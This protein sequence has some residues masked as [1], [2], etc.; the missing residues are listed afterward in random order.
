M[1]KRDKA[2]KFGPVE[3]VIL[4]L[5][6]LFVLVLIIPSTR[7]FRFYT[8]RSKCGSNLSQIGKAML[9][10]AADYDG[11][12]PRS[13]YGS[14]SS[15]FYL[16][17]KHSEV[18]PKIFVCPADVGTIEFNPANVV[19]D[20]KKLTD[21]WD[22]G[23]EPYKHCSY[24]YHMPFGLYYLRTSDEPGKP[25]AADRNP[26]ID[27]PAAEAK[28][29]FFMFNPDGGRESVKVANAVTHNE[30]GQNVVFLDG[31]VSFEENPSC[32]IG[33]DNI[34]TFWDG[35]DIRSGSRPK[36]GSEPIGKTDSLLVHDSRLYSVTGRIT[37]AKQS[38]SADSKD[39]KQTTVVATIDCPMPEHKNVIWC[40][41]FQIAWDRF[42]NDIIEEPI[43]LIGVQGLNDRLNSNEFSPENL[44]AESFYA[45][46][47]FFKDG[48]IEQIKKDMANRFPSEPVPVFDRKYETLPDV[49][50]AYAFL[51]V[52]AGFKYPFYTRNRKF[53]FQDSK[54][55]RTDVTSF[56][57][58]AE[59]RDS[60]YEKIREQVEVLYY[61]YGQ[62]GSVV[63][64]AI[65]LCT[66]TDPYQVI[67]ARVPRRQTLSETLSEVQKK[68]SEF[69]RDPDYDVLRKL[70]PIDSL[71]VPDILYKLTHR[72]PG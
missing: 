38:K 60:N 44:E 25:V 10:Y 35:G 9:A 28:E 4:I 5:V 40:G 8:Y 26:W 24:S 67:L 64:F 16:L 68:I 63:E 69:K 52:D 20:D 65:D 43:K 19:S 66:H 46:A 53:T 34:Y 51:S 56:S 62:E 7:M 37:T 32:G 54:G 12:L 72:A 30:Q 39:L 42:K 15:C 13:G 27:S 2:R 57:D 41:T 71:I 21:L 58:R 29:I 47:G 18:H 50:V 6:C 3:A 33:S 17:V 45:V 14:I 1:T 55:N 59:V 23:P 49:S 61:K 11:V 70:R 31:H 48:I 36:I 22:F